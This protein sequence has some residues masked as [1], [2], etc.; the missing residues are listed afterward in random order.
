MAEVLIYVMEKA[1]RFAERAQAALLQLCGGLK[2]D[3][4]EALLKAAVLSQSE[5]VRRTAIQG[6]QRVPLLARKQVPRRA[7]VGAI[8]WLACH[9]PDADNVEFAKVT[10]GLY[11]HALQ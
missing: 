7:R 5:A 1:P 8:L 2:V 9:D 6:L 10:F 11:T 4:F 3:D